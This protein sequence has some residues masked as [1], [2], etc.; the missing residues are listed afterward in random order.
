MVFVDMLIELYKM[1]NNKLLNDPLFVLVVDQQL[2]HV[3]LL[4]QILEAISFLHPPD[5][6]VLI[7]QPQVVLEVHIVLVLVQH[8]DLKII[9]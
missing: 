2:F 8:V 1:L 6:E 3:Q 7:N 9:K 5:K 4:V